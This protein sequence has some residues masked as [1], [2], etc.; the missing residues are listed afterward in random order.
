MEKEFRIEDADLCRFEDLKTGVEAYSFMR[1]RREQDVGC[2]Q[3]KHF[4]R[5]SC[6][7][8]DGDGGGGGRGEGGTRGGGVE[9]EWKLETVEV[10]LR[11]KIMMTVKPRSS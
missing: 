4:Q 5:K 7:E 6:I 10:M 1:I 11:I 8:Y 3:S 2:S 9:E